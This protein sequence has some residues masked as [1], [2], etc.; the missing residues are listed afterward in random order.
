MIISKNSLLCLVWFD[1]KIN[2]IHTYYYITIIIGIQYLTIFYYYL[3]VTCQ[4]H[5]TLMHAGRTLQAPTHTHTHPHT[6]SHTPH[7]HT[8]PHSHI[9]TPTHTYT[10]THTHTHRRTLTSLLVPT[11]STT[12]RHCCGGIPPIAVYRDSLPTG[13]PIPNAPKSPS[14]SILSP[15]VTTTACTG[16]RGEVV[17]L[18][19]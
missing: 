11:S 1:I 13:M 10:H 2:N 4:V 14:P 15:S 9:H 19:K 12:G 17:V 5:I 3:Y 16:G 6:H 7:T 18:T 8:H